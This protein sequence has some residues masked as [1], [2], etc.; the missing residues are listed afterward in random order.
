VKKQ[1]PPSAR[2]LLERGAY[3][4]ERAGVAES[5]WEA[6]RLLR[7]AL[8]WTRDYLIAHSDEPV[9]AEASGL[10]FH[11][12][13]RRRGREPLQYVLGVQDFWGLELR[14]TPS[15]LIPRPETEGLVEQTLARFRDRPARIV[16]VGC[17]S[18][19]IALALASKLPQA[20]V[21]ATEISPG[22]LAVARENAT[23]H[24]LARRVTFFQGDLL[25]PFLEKERAGKFD[26]V[27]SNPPYITDAEM[28]TLAPEV[29]EYEP[30]V[31]LAAGE[32]GLDVIGRLIPQAEELLTP[33]GYLLMEISEA[34]EP[35]CKE[36]LSKTTL[37]WEETVPDL[38]GIPRVL[39]AKKSRP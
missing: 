31:A 34:T 19:C 29:R 15:V 20:E 10:F 3:E 6:E 16:D 1:A 36:L 17:G 26:A 14:V 11:L 35:G 39:I 8:G 24:D 23:R 12:V 5:K 7:N 27:V 13:E 28:K 32:Q 9:P 4:L 25:Q 2:K 33:D 30:R 37:V 38:Q 21:F 22:A 18:G